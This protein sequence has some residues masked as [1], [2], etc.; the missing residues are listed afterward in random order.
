MKDGQPH[1]Y[2]GIMM[3][4]GDPSAQEYV[5]IGSGKTVSASIDLRA[6]YDFSRTGAYQITF[7]SKIHDVVS[8]ASQI[9]RPRSAFRGGYGE[10]RANS[11]V[12]RVEDGESSQ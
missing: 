1:P 9:P 6:G 10:V 2:R 5:C 4:R 3:K 8:D 7:D 11:I 12:I